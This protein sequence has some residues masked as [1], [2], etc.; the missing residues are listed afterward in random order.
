MLKSSLNAERSCKRLK[1][2]C[3]DAVTNAATALVNTVSGFITFNQRSMQQQP[4][5]HGRVSN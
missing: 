2:D 4:I 5:H 3:A 1:V